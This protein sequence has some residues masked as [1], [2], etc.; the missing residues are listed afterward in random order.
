[1]VEKLEP[2]TVP[3]VLTA[4]VPAAMPV[5]MVARNLIVV[6]FPAGNVKPLP[7]PLTV[8][9]SP[10]KRPSGEP[11]EGS[12]TEGVLPTT[13][14]TESSLGLSVGVVL[15]VTT[16]GGAKAG[17]AGLLGLRQV[18]SAT[19]VKV[20]KPL[21]T[22]VLALVELTGVLP[23]ASQAILIWSTG[24]APPLPFVANLIDVLV[25]PLRSL[26]DRRLLFC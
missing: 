10:D 17:A 1:M 21:T 12:I 25:C 6:L 8:T 23:L 22:T 3:C 5:L 13:A 11:P 9:V 26:N 24:V 7:E 4:H 16:T 15:S 19:S 14:T 20:P 18:L 2:D